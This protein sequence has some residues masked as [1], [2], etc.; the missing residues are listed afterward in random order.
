MIINIINTTVRNIHS[1]IHNGDRTHS[2]DHAI[3]PPSLSPI[4]KIANR[5]PKPI[6][7][8]ELIMFV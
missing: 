6:P 5:P 2:Q 1:G 8:D 3:T 4:N 7:D